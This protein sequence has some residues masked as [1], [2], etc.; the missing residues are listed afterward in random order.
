MMLSAV[1]NGDVAR[2]IAGMIAKCFATSLAIENV[3]NTPLVMSSCSPISTTSI[4]FVWF[5]IQIDH[6]ASFLRRLSARIHGEAH[7]GLGKRR[8]S[9]VPSP[10]MA[11]SF[12]PPARCLMSAISSSGAGLGQG[13]VKRRPRTRRGAQ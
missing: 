4:S 9:L 1:E 12:R 6:V 8:A 7:V 10:V 11:T 5:R 13:V 2:E 3:V